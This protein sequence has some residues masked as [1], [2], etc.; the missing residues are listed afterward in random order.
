MAAGQAIAK[1]ET[2]KYAYEPG[3]ISIPAEEYNR[4]LTEKVRLEMELK[5]AREE[6]AVRKTVETLKRD[7]LQ[8][9]KGIVTD[10]D[11]G[12]QREIQIPAFMTNRRQRENGRI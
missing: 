8:E 11:T 3:Y 10:S 12:K 1:F 9:I 7:L 5:Q 6:L 2:G 4:L